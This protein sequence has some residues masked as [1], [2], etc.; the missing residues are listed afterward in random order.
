MAHKSKI[1]FDEFKELQSALNKGE[2]FTFIVS[3]DSMEPVIK[4]GEE[5]VVEPIREPLKL[6]DII[7]FFQN[8]DL[9]CHM[10]IKPSRLNDGF[11]TSSY[12]YKSYDFPVKK[13]NVLGVI[14]SHRVGFFRKL[15]FL[16]KKG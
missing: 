12:K 13:E 6:F 10:Y 3:S 5:V 1:S 15:Q 2:P 7:V 8:N 9:L 16:M 14:G 4:T 11:L